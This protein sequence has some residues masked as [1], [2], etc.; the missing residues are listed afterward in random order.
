MVNIHAGV[1]FLPL[2]H[3]YQ[4]LAPLF[5]IYINYLS[6]GLQC[7]PKLFVDDTSLFATIHNIKKSKNDLNNDLTK[8]M[9]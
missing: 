3:K 5:F 2:F 7:N 6:D 9:K 1:M 8:I 4:S